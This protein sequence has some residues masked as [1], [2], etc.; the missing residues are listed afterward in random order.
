M[1]QDPGICAD[2]AAP[3]DFG[4]EARSC[5]RSG[6]DAVGTGVGPFS[7]A[8]V[9]AGFDFVVG[10]LNPSVKVDGLGRVGWFEFWA[11]HSEVVCAGSAEVLEGA[12]KTLGDDLF[13]LRGAR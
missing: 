5:V 10:L 8:G 7:A 6:R 2:A 1:R 4:L 11:T 13:E 9:S 3:L 12:G